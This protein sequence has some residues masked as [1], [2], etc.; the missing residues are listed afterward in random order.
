V[1]CDI[2]HERLKK[3]ALRAWWYMQRLGQPDPTHEIH[4]SLLVDSEQG[5][6]FVLHVISNHHAN[7]QGQSNHTADEYKQVDKYGMKL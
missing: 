5:S 4:P 1:L 6:A 7:K 2:I 3:K